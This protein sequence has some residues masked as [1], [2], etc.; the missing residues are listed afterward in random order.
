MERRTL[1]LIRIW[2]RPLGGVGMG[3]WGT[4]TPKERCKTEG[5]DPLTPDPAGESAGCGPPSVAAAT[6]GA[7]STLPSVAAATEGRVD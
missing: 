4:L 3:E 2:I 6:E 5:Q 7:N 1:F